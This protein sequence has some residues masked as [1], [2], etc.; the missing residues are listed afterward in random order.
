VRAACWRDSVL[1]CNCCLFVVF[2][3]AC[4]CAL[5]FF[6]GGASGQDGAHNLRGESVQS[7]GPEPN[8]RIVAAP[9]CAVA[10][11]RVLGCAVTRSMMIYRDPTNAWCA[12]ASGQCAHIKSVSRVNNH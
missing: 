5:L 12:V 1:L 10:R 4:V 3:F 2:V 6:I 8:V 7:V 11:V 9:N